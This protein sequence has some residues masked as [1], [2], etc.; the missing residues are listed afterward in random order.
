MISLCKEYYQFFLA[1]GILQGVGQAFLVCPVIAVISQHFSKNR[2]LATGSTIAGSSLGGIIW[3]I[4]LNQLLNARGI[5][6]PWT[7]R[8][9]AFTMLPLIAI[10]CATVLPPATAKSTS[11]DTPAASHSEKPKKKA[12]LSLLKSPVFL[13]FCA[14]LGIFYLG[15]F[16]PY[17]FLTSYAVNGGMSTSFAFYLVSILNAASLVGRVSA[18]WFADKYGH[19]NVCSLCGLFSAL[20]VFCWTAADSSA[21]LVMWSLAYGFV[22][23]FSPS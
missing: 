18:G 9:I 14:G 4:M 12:D 20:V 7:I 16:S 17:F 5:S 6:F 2:G 21:G 23:P 22:W 15:M 13:T 11:E 19:F 10:T 8:I 1:Q 3:P